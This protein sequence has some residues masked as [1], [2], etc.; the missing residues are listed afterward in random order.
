MRASDIWKF[1]KDRCQF[2]S[3]AATSNAIDI[4]A[5][6]LEQLQAS[7]KLEQGYRRRDGNRIWDLE[8]RAKEKQ[9]PL[10]LPPP[11]AADIV[12]TFRPKIISAKLNKRDIEL[13]FEHG[14]WKFSSA[15]LEVGDDSL[16]PSGTL[17]ER[18]AQVEKWLL[19]G[20]A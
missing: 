17:P 11:T 8:L 5:E 13:V 19:T 4:L 10:P 20:K 1:A 16:F 15:R 18:L 2:N 14:E 9:E 3:R 7:F 12:W 6:Q